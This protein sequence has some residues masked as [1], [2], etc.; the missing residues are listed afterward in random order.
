MAAGFLVAVAMLFPAFWAVF[1]A[2]WLLLYG[3]VIALQ[4]ILRNGI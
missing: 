2:I 3:C 4:S 1:G